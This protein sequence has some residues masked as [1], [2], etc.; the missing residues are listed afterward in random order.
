[1]K[2]TLTLLTMLLVVFAYATN[3]WKSYYSDNSVQIFYRYTDCH[4]DTNGI[5]QQKVVFRFVNLTNKNI[6]VSFAKQLV[7]SNQT[8]SGA[9]KPFSLS[10]LPKQT[11]EGT[12]NEKNKTLFSYAKQL[13]T[14]CAQLQEFKLTNITVKIIQ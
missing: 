3:E 11:V 2:H 4:D 13:N 7:Y 10:L 12:C 8:A 1:M 6:E 14:N 9:D 5:H